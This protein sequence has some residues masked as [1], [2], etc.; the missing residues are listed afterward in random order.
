MSMV[1]D[2]VSRLGIVMVSWAGRVHLIADLEF[3]D[4]RLAGHGLGGLA[5]IAVWPTSLR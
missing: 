3:S 2:E 5:D 1:T 4:A